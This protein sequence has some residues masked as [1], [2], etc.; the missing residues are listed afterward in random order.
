[1]RGLLDMT[2]VDPA[3]VLAIGAVK[4]D[5]RRCG[6]MRRMTLEYD[7]GKVGYV[8]RCEKCGRVSPGLMLSDAY[9]WESSA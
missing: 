1:M 2:G 3:R 8:G 9:V 4:A 6:K 7:V 5:C